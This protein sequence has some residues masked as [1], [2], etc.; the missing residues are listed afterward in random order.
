MSYA[1]LIALREF[2][3]NAKTKGF[4]F[5]IFM[6]PLMIAAA[7]GIT[8]WAERSE[9]SRHFVLVD[10]SGAFAESIEQSV[11]RA[12]QRSVLQAVG[13]YIRQNLS[14]G[15]RDAI[16][17]SAVPADGG[18]PVDPAA[19]DKGLGELLKRIR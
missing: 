15:E 19:V 12:Y 9:P 1:F 7:I 4:W 13:R 11:E 16:D 6:F 3:E 14:G 2:V 18:P 5:G 8:A 17:L 10:Q